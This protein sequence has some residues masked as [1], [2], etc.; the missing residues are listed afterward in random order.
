MPATHLSCTA[1][2]QPPLLI[3]IPLSIRG[4]IIDSWNGLGV[5]GLEELWS[6]FLPKPF[7][8]SKVLYDLSEM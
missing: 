6:S 4:E 2:T 7:Y 3:S 5:K 8:Y 1:S